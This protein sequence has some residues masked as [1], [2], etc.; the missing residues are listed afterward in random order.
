MHPFVTV[1][2]GT[3][4]VLFS[5]FNVWVMLVKNSPRFMENDKRQLEDLEVHPSAL[6]RE[7]FGGAATPAPD[8]STIGE[9]VH[10]EFVHSGRMFQL[11]SDQTVLHAA[12]TNG[13]FL[14]YSCRQGLCGCVQSGY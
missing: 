8:V 14:P 4:F 3:I 13:V 10:A 2:A 1:A 6:L 9:P 11:P 12:E 5:G 7:S